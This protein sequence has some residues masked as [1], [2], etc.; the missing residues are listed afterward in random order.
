MWLIFVGVI[1][2]VTFLLAASFIVKKCCSYGKQ[3]KIGQN[4]SL[5]EVSTKTNTVLY[6]S[7]TVAIDI[8][9][10]N[11]SPELEEIEVE[12]NQKEVEI[13]IVTTPISEEVI[14]E[15]SLKDDAAVNVTDI[16]ESTFWKTNE[17]NES[18]DKC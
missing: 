3:A 16:F 12:E 8:V 13:D 2:G 6:P 4:E 1:A 14:E 10:D 9:K 7:K 5:T 18:H 17:D 15:K 11:S